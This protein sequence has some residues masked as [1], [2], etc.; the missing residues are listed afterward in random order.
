MEV[1]SPP[2]LPLPAGLPH[3]SGM[4]CLKSSVSS[5]L[6]VPSHVLTDRRVKFTVVAGIPVQLSQGWRPQLP[7]P[8]ALQSRVAELRLRSRAHT[9]TPP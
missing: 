8:A 7:L 1:S 5:G 3:G 6:R 9:P 4:T 2:C